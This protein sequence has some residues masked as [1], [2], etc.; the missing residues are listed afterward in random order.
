MEL[1][2]FVGRRDKI[3][4][5]IRDKIYCRTLVLKQDV[6]IALV[7]CDVLG[8]PSEVAYSI[9]EY[10]RRIGINNTVIMATHTHYA[11]ATIQMRM[12][13]NVDQEYLKLFEDK[14]KGSIEEAVNRLVSVMDVTIT[15]G[16]AEG[17]CMKRIVRR[18]VKNNVIMIKFNGNAKSVIINFNCHP[19]TLGPYYRYI[20]SDYASY[21]YNYFSERGIEA[22][23]INGAA[24]DV[25]PGVSGED[26]ITIIGE[27]IIRAL[28]RGETMNLTPQLEARTVNVTLTKRMERL[29]T[30]KRIYYELLSRVIKTP[31][32]L[33]MR[34]WSRDLI[35]AIRRGELAYEE[36]V[37]I[38][39]IK[40][41]REAAIVTCPCELSSTLGEA[42]MSKSPFKYTVI[43]GYANGYIGY[44]I[45]P[46]LAGRAHYELGESYRFHD[47][48]PLSKDSADKIV[49]AMLG[50]LN[51]LTK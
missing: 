5:G 1:S 51:D 46:A 2:G 40:V 38:T 27:G 13:G 22:L 45:D 28:N 36:R 14:I 7:S 20:S 29:I 30:M 10:A 49:H 23:F 41:S 8:I 47:L 50:V 25:N 39:G 12:A 18:P 42:I 3:Y 19:I 11:P 9:D 48:L 37:S 26:G 31:W 4:I 21:I 15:E 6:A 34:D 33:A 32:T 24:G 16:D 43:A 17:L 44:I 35:N